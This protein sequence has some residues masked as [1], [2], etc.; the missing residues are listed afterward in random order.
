MTMT[1]FDP[2]RVVVGRQIHAFFVLWRNNNE[3]VQLRP[4]ISKPDSLE[5]YLHDMQ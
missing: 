3:K 4:I 5:H 1:A 2:K